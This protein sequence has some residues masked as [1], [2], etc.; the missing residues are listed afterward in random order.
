[1]QG[2]GVNG[3]LRINT[4]H[5]T[6]VPIWTWWIA[7]WAFSGF[8]IIQLL[9]HLSLDE[10]VKIDDEDDGESEEDEARKCQHCDHT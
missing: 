5:I 1:M 8:H 7:A 9:L 6:M 4:N 3:L 2:A 10:D